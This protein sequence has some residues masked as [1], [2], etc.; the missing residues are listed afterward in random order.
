MRLFSY[1]DECCVEMI[2]PFPQCCENNS[3]FAF[4]FPHLDGSFTFP[5]SVTPLVH[6]A[7][8]SINRSS[9]RPQSEH[10]GS[11]SGENTLTPKHSSHIFLFTGFS[12]VIF[13]NRVS[14]SDHMVAS[15]VFEVNN[16]F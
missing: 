15:I 3:G 16:F 11:P 10:V 1:V 14:N 7:V 13:G 5:S 6:S 2:V 4:G 12:S 8:S 9:T